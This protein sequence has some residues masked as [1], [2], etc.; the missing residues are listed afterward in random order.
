VERDAPPDSWRRTVARQQKG[1]TTKFGPAQCVGSGAFDETQV[2]GRGLYV[3]A[4][5]ELRGYRGKHA[6]LRWTLFDA[7]D[8][9]PHPEGSMREQLGVE[10]AVGSNDSRFDIPFG[11]PVPTSGG[12]YFIRVAVTDVDGHRLA[13]EDSATISVSSGRPS[14]GMATSTSSSEQPSSEVTTEE[15]PPPQG[16][17]RATWVRKMDTVCGAVKRDAAER[18][19]S[20]RD[21]TGAIE[22]NERLNADWQR[23]VQAAQAVPPAVPDR[24]RVAEMISAWDEAGRFFAELALDIRNQDEPSYNAHLRDGRMKA[25]SG[26][27]IAV[28]LGATRCR[29]L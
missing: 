1:D 13:A 17:T 16:R 22:Y 25:T 11:V 24:A 3:N 29:D 18:G 19:L 21:A 5:V 10:I 7:R 6:C 27:E 8:R 12:S 28:Q 23:F 4:E 26:S 14:A 20:P 2:Q 9:T 15:S